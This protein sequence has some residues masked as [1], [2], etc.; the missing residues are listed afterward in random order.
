MYLPVEIRIMNLAWTLISEDKDELMDGKNIRRKNC[1][2]AY[3]I[4]MFY[5]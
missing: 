4:R 5:K 2:E 1:Y 3:H